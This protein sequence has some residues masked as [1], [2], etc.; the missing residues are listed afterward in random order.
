[1]GLVESALLATFVLYAYAR[2]KAKSYEAALQ[3]REKMIPPLRALLEDNECS[4]EAKKMALGM[5]YASLSPGILVKA[6]FLSL[7]HAPEKSALTSKERKALAY[8]LERHFLPV[9]VLAGMHWYVFAALLG[10]LVFSIVSMFRVV[11]PRRFKSRLETELERE[12]MA[13]AP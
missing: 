2:Y 10:L 1:M 5:F 7:F 3:C 4:A 12:F 6:I 8:L 11:A 13:H 9:N